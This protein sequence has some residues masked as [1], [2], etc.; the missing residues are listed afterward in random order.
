MINVG[1]KIQ[2]LG[3]HAEALFALR[4]HCVMRRGQGLRPFPLV[5]FKVASM[6]ELTGTR[7]ASGCSIASLPMPR[8]TM[9]SGLRAGMESPS[10]FSKTRQ[11]LVL[12]RE[13]RFKYS[14]PHQRFRP[15]RWL[16]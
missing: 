10:G 2:I 15:V 7:I 6:I 12:A 3:L 16:A 9:A 1:S 11:V 5:R 13:W 14:H 8:A 4:G